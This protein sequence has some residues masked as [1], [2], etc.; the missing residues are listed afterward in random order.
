VDV[1]VSKVVDGKKKKAVKVWSEPE[2]I[3]LSSSD[4]AV[5]GMRDD[6]ERA[7]AKLAKASPIRPKEQYQVSLS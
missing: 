1:V 6:N 4:A 5:G 7:E 2:A 3:D